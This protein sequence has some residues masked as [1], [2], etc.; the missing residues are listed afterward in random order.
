MSILIILLQ[1][2]TLSMLTILCVSGGGKLLLLSV[3][4]T[5]VSLI[6]NGIVEVLKWKRKKRK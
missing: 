1:A 6:L 3:I 2:A 5:A 4:L